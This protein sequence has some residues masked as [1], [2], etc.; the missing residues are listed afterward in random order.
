M[1][2]KQPDRKWLSDFF[3]RL[4][5]KGRAICPY[6]SNKEC[7]RSVFV[8]RT[9][10]RWLSGK[11]FACIEE[12]GTGLRLVPKAGYGCYGDDTEYKVRSKVRLAVARVEYTLN[13]GPDEVSF[14]IYYAHPVKGGAA[15]IRSLAW[16][17]LAKLEYRAISEK[18]FDRIAALFKDD[19]GYV[20]PPE[21]KET[22]CVI[23]R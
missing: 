10:N 22:K 12:I 23:Y 11:Y 2:Y 4:H 21:D 18:E 9:L 17:Q 6:R 7:N 15:N 5:K 14:W 3:D 16:H 1:K 13:W 19:S 8:R 20:A